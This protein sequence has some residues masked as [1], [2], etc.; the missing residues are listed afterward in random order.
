VRGE[1]GREGWVH[2]RRPEEGLKYGEDVCP[3]TFEM[4][5]NWH[6]WT[7]FYFLEIIDVTASNRGLSAPGGGA[8]N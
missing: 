7:Y 4:V 6:F 2:C 1:L 8:G 5:F 3:Y